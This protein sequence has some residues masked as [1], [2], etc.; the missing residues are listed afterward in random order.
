MNER[1]PDFI[2]IGAAKAGTTSLYH[3][4]IR[5]PRIFMSSPKE[6]T[7][8]ARDERYERGRHWYASLFSNAQ[9]HQVCGEASTNYTNWPLYPQT[10]GRMAS[11]LKDVKLIYLV[12]HP[13]NRAYSHYL[14]LIENIRADNPDYKFEQHFEDAIENDPSILDSSRY[15]LQIEQYLNHYP[16]DQLLVMQFENFVKDPGT[17]LGEVLSF[18]GLNPSFN[19]L[20]QGEVKDN[21]KRDKDA[22][23]IRSRLTRPLTQLPGGQFMTGI[24]PQWAKNLIYSAL[25]R[26]PKRAALERAFIPPPMTP[27]IRARLLAEFAADNERLAKFLNMNLSHWNI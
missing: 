20:A 13:V 14:Q 22:W 23:T 11:M 3:Y 4:L 27:E 24:M 18:I 12:R 2:V 16:R 15:M 8:F 5:H 9:P 19:F 7:Y 10:V 26:T 21:V 6:P 17:T 1:L 25:E